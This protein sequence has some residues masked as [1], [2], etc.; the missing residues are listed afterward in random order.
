MLSPTS[1]VNSQQVRPAAALKGPVLWLVSPS[2]APL[3]R[4]GLP[5]NHAKGDQRQGQTST[6]PSAALQQG[7][8]RDGGSQ[9]K[10]QEATDTSQ[11]VR[12]FC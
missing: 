4:V 9:E 10:G 1:T 7:L 12:N 8:E 6:P 5:P 2:T 11:H 3:L